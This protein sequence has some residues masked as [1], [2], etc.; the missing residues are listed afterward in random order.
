MAEFIRKIV[1]RMR[2]PPALPNN[3]TNL[4]CT[5]KLKQA[6]GKI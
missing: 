1:I 3:R 4:I 5:L 2:S 6:C